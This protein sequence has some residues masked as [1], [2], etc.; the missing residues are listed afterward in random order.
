MLDV[1]RSEARDLQYQATASAAA[2]QAP[3][4]FPQPLG[5]ITIDPSKVRDLRAEALDAAG[6][7]RVLPAAFWAGT[8]ME[9]RG[10]FGHRTGIYSFPT[11]ELVAHLRGIIDGRTAIEIGA[12]HGVLAE[13][14][15]IPATDSRQQDVPKY[16][17]YYAR[18]GLTTVPYG[19]NVAELSAS[20][21]VRRYKPQVVIGCWVTW[22]FRPKR[23]ASANYDPTQPFGLGN[24]KGVDEL[25]VLRNCET[26]VLVGNDKTHAASR[27]WERP[28]EVEYPPFVFSRAI[29]GGREFVATWRGGQA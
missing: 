9:E 26:Y 22:K 8:T 29:N 20:Q 23:P 14:L 3:A 12:G 19:P 17:E 5:G 10:L 15:D 24:E 16:R 18:R 1:S 2:R 6:R 13:A 28:H 11:E 27:L 4:A 25:N 21:A 7:I